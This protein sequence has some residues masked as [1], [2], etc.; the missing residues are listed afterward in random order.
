MAPAL[1]SQ[2]RKAAARGRAPRATVG[3]VI[4]T[5]APSGDEAEAERIAA[6]CGPAVRARPRA[7]LTLDLLLEEAAGAPVLVLGVNRADLHLPVRGGVRSFRASVGMAFLRLLRARKGEV[8]PLVQMAGLTWGETVLDA[9]LGLGGDA[10]IAANATGMQ[11]IGLEV[12]PVL[13]A[14][15][16]AGLLRLP[17]PGREPG[18][19]IE[20]RWADHRQALRELPARSVD[21]VLLDPMFRSAG[22]AGPLFELVREHADHTPLDAATLA[23]A[24]RVARRGVLIKDRAPGWELRALGLEPRQTRRSS[25]IAFAW[26][27]AS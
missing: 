1:G 17:E 20:V 5:T 27:S 19:R 21:V 4:V 8:D 2:E 3:G 10:V 9:T 23:E 24:R 13:A 25:P 18:R 6:R 26:V 16:M 7:G 15:A 14:F 12:S 22:E 11:V